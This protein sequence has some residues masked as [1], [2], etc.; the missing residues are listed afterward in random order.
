VA[1]DL[2]DRRG[3]Y[4][5]AEP[6]VKEENHGTNDVGSS[7]GGEPVAIPWR[8]R[9][10]TATPSEDESMPIPRPIRPAIALVTTLVVAGACG[11]GSATDPSPA[12]PTLA[13]QP[14]AAADTWW[15]RATTR[16]AIPPVGRFGVPPVAVVTGD[17][18]Y[19]TVGPTD[20]M[21][22]GPALPNLIGRPIDEAG[23]A[24]ILAEAQRLGLLSGQ[25]DFTG[26]AGMAGGI[27]G[28]IELTVNGDRVTL[29]GD[30][31]ASI[32]CITTPCDP[33]PGTPAAFAEM[34][35]RLQ[36]PES[37]LGDSIGPEAPYV[38]DA[39]ALLIG[40]P[41]P[42]ELAIPTPVIDWPLETAA[43]G[44]GVPVANN[45]RRCGNAIGDDA[46]AIRPALEQATQASPWSQDP[47]TSATFGV[48]ARPFVPGED[49][50]AETFGS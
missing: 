11:L 15:L 6:R 7:H 5:A 8:Q 14:S 33:P 38:A 47:T 32:Q 10:V 31:E 35:S 44:F 39:Y 37:G 20:A 21:Y 43:G 23:R 48:V 1:S 9:H 25:T 4:A 29:T 46:A 45:T 34:W 13:P 12:A 24:R 16:Q 18:T 30:L 26:G 17:G 36:E 42:P 40:P 2:L 22:P 19:I 28:Q 27:T 3:Y 49:P 50:C 41:P